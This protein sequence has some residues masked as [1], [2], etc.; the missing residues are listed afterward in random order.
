MRRTGRHRWACRLRGGAPIRLPTGTRDRRPLPILA[1]QN[2]LLGIDPEVGNA[3][4]GWKVLEYLREEAIALDRVILFTDMQLWDATGGLVS[5]DRTVREEF[6]A[7]REAIAPEVS[8]YVIDL[9]AYGGFVTPE[10]YEN[11]YNISGWTETVLK[12]IG[13]AEAPRQVIETIEATV[14]M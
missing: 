5:D 6:E 13:N 4:N 12:F 1:R 14:P 8:L 7:Y 11:V 3:T 9:A 2:A 10:G